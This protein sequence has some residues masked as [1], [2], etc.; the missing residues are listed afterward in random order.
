M[1][2]ARP[3]L[4]M[5]VVLL[6]VRFGIASLLRL[7]QSTGLPQLPAGR[8]ALVS[9]TYYGLRLPFEEFIGHHRWGYRVPQ[10]GESVVFTLTGATQA[11][12]HVGVVR[13]VPGDV[14]WIDPERRKVLP[15]R[16]SPVAERLIIPG[17]QQSV[18][19]TP[20]NAR[21]L[22]YVMKHY[23][24]CTTVKAD[25]LGTLMLDNQPIN[26]VRLMNNYYWVET[27]PDSFLLIPHRELVGRLFIVSHR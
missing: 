9:R 21:L 24:Q 22:A 3:F 8:Y 20:H 15:A 2:Y 23:E 26:R 16:T 12:T 10:A 6:V 25:T 1:A 11:T 19:V 13:A 5:L 14:V 7:P 18:R 27:R 4:I 17:K